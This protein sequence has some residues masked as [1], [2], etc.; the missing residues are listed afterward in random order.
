MNRSVQWTRLFLVTGSMFLSFSGRTQEQKLYGYEIP[1]LS[2]LPSVVT[3]VIE[4]QIS[5]NG[6][7]NFRIVGHMPYHSIQVPGE[8]EMQGFTVNEGETALYSRDFTIPK[9]WKGKRI[10]LRFDAVSS[11]C[12]VK[13][14]G[15]K[16]AEHEGS[17]VPFET[18]ITDV[19]SEGK[20]I[21][22]A[23]VQALTVSDHLACTSQYAAHIVGGILRKVTLF[24]LPP[25]NISR[26]NIITTFTDQFKKANLTVH[27]TVA[28]ESEWPGKV[29]LKFLLVDAKGKSVLQLTYDVKS[30]PNTDF[31]AS[32]IRTLNNPNKWDPEHPY[33][34]ML[35]TEL[36]SSGKLLQSN[37]QQVGFRQIDILGNQLLVNGLSV[38]LH[39]VNRHEVYPLTG[40]S[41]T[42][43]L[44]RKDAEIFREANC[45][46][47]RTSHYPPSEEFLDAADEL[48]LFVESESSL[49]WIDHET[50]P[51]WKKWD[52]LNPIFLPLM[53]AANVEKVNA[54]RNHP[55]IL[56]W[57]L[58]NE[59]RWNPSWIMVNKVVKQL[60]P[61]RPTTFHDQ[62]WGGYNNAGSQADIAVYH[63]PGA[64]GP[65]ACDS[66]KRP[67]LFGEYAHISC[68]NR[69]EVATDPGIRDAYG[70]PLV[71]MYDSMY[72]H[73]GCLGGAIWSGID[74]IFHM[75]DGRIIG[76]GPWG[77]IDGWRRTKPEYYGMKKAYSPVV[78]TNIDHPTVEGN[79]LKLFVENRYNFT[80]MKEV[81]ITC[82]VDGRIQDVAFS[83]PP[84]GEGVLAIPISQETKEVK[85]SFY[86]PR[87]FI[88]N[89]E[90]IV[91]KEDAALPITKTEVTVSEDEAA[92]TVIQGNVTYL[93]SKLNGM[94]LSA[95]K[96]EKELLSQ[97]PVFGIVPMNEED[98]GKPGG[99]TYQNDI[100]PIKNYPLYTLIAR[101][102]SAQK[103]SDG[104]K[105]SMDVT[106]TDGEGEQS[107]FFSYD[108]KITTEYEVSYRGI[109]SLPRQYGMIMQLPR[110]F[111]N[112]RWKRKGDFSLY[113]A[114]DIG[115]NE[116][117]AQLNAKPVN[118]VE[119]WGAVP[120]G[121]WKDDANAMGSNDFRSTKRHI[122]EASLADE[123]GDHITVLSDGSQS[124][125]CW[126]QD[127]HI[128]WLIA[129]YNNNGSEPFYCPPHSNG[130]IT[131]KKNQLIK[132]KLVLAIR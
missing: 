64:N 37:R 96:D 62:C 46:Y 124:S 18:D 19:I 93:I 76:Y 12:V 6:T 85:L 126:L 80:D 8:W 82:S 33:L 91:L 98:G 25:V 128:S 13:V 129:E 113:P 66:M 67:V 45:N 74:D 97:G 108:G 1:R 39:G 9:D 53:M 109:D 61:T 24:A 40:R 59:S 14:N 132:G 21:L 117:V 47:I 20:N 88:A 32:V 83:V 111:V 44:C 115:R 56:I 50:S 31:A 87:G 36:Y 92:F 51:F 118:G 72:F 103:L 94:I 95:K 43:Q 116:G 79:L 5:L 114:N 86:D 100:Y 29:L 57:S 105:I 42:P 99:V 68:Y 75:P 23:E 63:Y 10:K 90:K 27:F 52:Y 106:Y 38:K 71:Q 34:Y 65:A 48:G 55:S 84:H 58:G 81:S 107:Y 54:Q 89:E 17:F 101:N 60:D 4:P 104:L 7:W 2:P 112:L 130:R 30:D 123:E 16:T 69:R 70:A 26:Q 119:V 73:P 120:L 102:V 28:N 41:I 125:R 15:K 122:K 78:I 11:Y 131:L 3:G 127:E 110:S 49:C 121:D 22:Q 77:P 35:L